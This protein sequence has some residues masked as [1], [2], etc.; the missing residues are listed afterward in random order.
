MNVDLLFQL[1]QDF[2]ILI[3]QMKVILGKPDEVSS[4]ISQLSQFQSHLKKNNW[5]LESERQNHQNFG[6]FDRIHLFLTVEKGSRENWY[7]TQL[8]QEKFLEKLIFQTS[9]LIH[10][11]NN[12]ENIT[13]ET[14]LETPCFS[15]FC[16]L[17]DLISFEIQADRKGLKLNQSPLDLEKI[18]LSIETYLK[19][20]RQSLTLKDRLKEPE[21]YK[22]ILELEEYLL[23]LQ[24]AQKDIDLHKNELKRQQQEW[25]RQQQE[26]LYHQ[27]QQWLL[28]Q[29]E[30]LRRQQQEWFDLQKNELKRQQQEWL[31]Q[32]RVELEETRLRDSK[33]KPEVK[34]TQKTRSFNGISLLFLILVVTLLSS[35]G[36]VNKNPF[37]IGQ[38]L[39]LLSTPQKTERNLKSAQALA[40][41]ASEIVENPPHPLTAWQAAQNKWAESIS[42]LQ[43]IYPNLTRSKL[44]EEQLNLYQS[45]YN[46]V[47]QKLLQEQTAV[48]QFKTAKKIA[49]EASVF[50][51]NPPY[52]VSTWQEAQDKWQQAINLLETI[53]QN[54]F[55]APEVQE[56]LEV[57][58]LNA[59]EI[60]K[61]M[62]MQQQAQENP[63]TEQSNQP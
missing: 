49:L 19:T 54:S 10:L 32:Q 26:E 30:Q 48:T 22:L 23:M 53:P 25:L 60:D 5:D 29:R 33:P 31:S 56:K 44:V 52:P 11:L 20:L 37:K 15:V 61:R 55:I 35:V 38:K 6:A 45:D 4:I 1:K 2:Q 43:A 57:Y 27:Q 63:I 16:N 41:E 46:S 58:R 51:K 47:Q 17:L 36:L 12:L 62:I 18:I 40:L 14:N 28:Q 21:K 42:L 24:V 3:E 9:I 34:K 8:Q 7:A 13:P 50:V 39:N 59:E